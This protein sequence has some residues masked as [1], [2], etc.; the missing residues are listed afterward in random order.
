QDR[1]IDCFFSRTRKRPLPRKLIQSSHVRL[2]AC[3]LILMGLSGLFLN[4]VSFLP[5]L[6]GLIAILLYNGLYTPL[7]EKTVLAIIPGTIC[8]MMP[9]LIGWTA[10]GGNLR[11]PEIWMLMTLIGLWQLPHFW[12]LILANRMEYCLSDIPNMLNIFTVGKLKNILF[13]WVLAFAC[14]AL[15][16]PA[17][18]I[19]KTPWMQWLLL[20]YFIPLLCFFGFSL[21]PKQKSSDYPGLFIYLNISMGFVLLLIVAD[22]FYLV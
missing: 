8:G 4:R 14:M 11:V 16:L 21:L 13:V 12:L 19:L 7:K 5:V 6:I 15:F 9:P 22:S 2:F 3:V 18:R 20:I 17:F 10:A 1:A